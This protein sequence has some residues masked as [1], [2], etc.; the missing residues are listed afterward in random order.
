MKPIDGYTI[1]IFQFCSVILDEDKNRY[2]P[3]P[4]PLPQRGEGILAK[5]ANGIEEI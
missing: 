2:P 4:N 3:H 5:D 1:K